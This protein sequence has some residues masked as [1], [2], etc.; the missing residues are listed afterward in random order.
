MIGWFNFILKEW[1]TI[2]SGR[3]S[4][5]QLW[6]WFILVSEERGPKINHF[7]RLLY[8]TNN[9]T[10]NNNS[11]NHNSSNSNDNSSNGSNHKNS[12][13]HNSNN[14]VI[15]TTICNIE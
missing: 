9:N 6:K 2:I 7:H 13:N 5:K 15:Q 14:T 4:L 11:S 1:L 12:S 3:S 8:Y 10:N